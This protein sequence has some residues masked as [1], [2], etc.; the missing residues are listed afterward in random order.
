MEIKCKRKVYKFVN[1]IDVQRNLGDKI[2]SSLK[3]AAHV[4]RV[5]IKAYGM[6]AFVG[7]GIEYRSQEVTRQLYKTLL[8]CTAS[9]ACSSS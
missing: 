8:G 5:V 2:H 6:F 1:R 4:D 9:V 7:P 3:V